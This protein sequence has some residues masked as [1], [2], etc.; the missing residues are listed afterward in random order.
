MSTDLEA[1]ITAALTTDIASADIAALITETEGAVTQAEATAEA[2]RKKALDPVV[3]PDATKAREAMQA[4]EFRRDRLR[5][6]SPRLQMRLRQ[7]RAEEELARWLPQHEAAK[8][9]RDALAEKLCELYVPFSNEFLA[10]G[11]EIEK[12][13]AEVRRVNAAKPDEGASGKLLLSVEEQARGRE[14]F[15]M[16][17]LQIMKDVRLPAWE[18]SPT[19]VWPPH[20]PLD[21]ASIVGRTP[22]DPR[23]YTDRWYEVGE[24]RAQAR[25]DALAREAQTWRRGP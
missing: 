18:G 15:K 10:L 14:A 4:A 6:L 13:D 12:A 1:R 21:A 7:V 17:Y 2:E 8:A 19:Q 20:R 24:E 5:T 16:G 11:L 3:S 9:R 22:G 25:A 23:L